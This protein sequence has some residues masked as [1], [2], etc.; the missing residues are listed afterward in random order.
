[1]NGSL[2]T[3]NVIRLILTTPPAKVL[4]GE[5]TERSHVIIT[6]RLSAE[7]RIRRMS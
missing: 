7:R 5:P 4:S 3:R 2:L 1:M 6:R